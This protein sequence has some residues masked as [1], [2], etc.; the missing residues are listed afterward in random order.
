MFN[1]FRVPPIR[2]CWRP[3]DSRSKTQLSAV[4]RRVGVLPFRAL[5]FRIGVV[6]VGVGALEVGLRGTSLSD[7]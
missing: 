5:A 7:F 1:N 3:R 2:Q 6:G 4:S